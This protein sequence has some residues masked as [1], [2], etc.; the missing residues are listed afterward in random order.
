MAGKAVAQCQLSLQQQLLQ[1]CSSWQQHQVGLMS[2]SPVTAIHDS[3]SVISQGGID[4]AG[5]CRYIKGA[6]IH[7]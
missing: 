5:R 4:T 7:V 3:W 2:S 6:P 1:T